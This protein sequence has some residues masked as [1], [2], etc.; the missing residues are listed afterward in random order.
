MIRLA[1]A[2][3]PSAVFSTAPLNLWPMHVAILNYS[4]NVG[5]STIARLCLRPRMRSCPVFFVESINEGGDASNI[6][7]RHFRDV[8]VEISVLDNA[9]VDIGS[10]NIEQVLIQLNRMEDAHEDFDYYVIPTVPSQKQQRDT[11][12]TF[13][14]L[15]EMGILPDKIR[16]VLN[17]AEPDTDCRKQFSLVMAALEI[18]DLRFEAVIYMSEVF[19]LLENL[20]LEQAI[21]EGTDFKAK[22]AATADVELK[23]DLARALGI[24]RLARTAR[25]D[26]DAAFESMFASV[27][28]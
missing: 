12:R 4:G 22:I 21:S 7:G 1:T 28:T 20:T 17:Q 14:A 18:F 6:G 19:P 24:S 25:K 10:S 2:A 23:R 15:M 9:I 11:I 8:L 16:I 26:L 27:K 13:H 3:N 5:K